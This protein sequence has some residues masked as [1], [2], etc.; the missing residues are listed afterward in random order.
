MSFSTKKSL[1]LCW[2]PLQRTAHLNRSTKEWTGSL[3]VQSNER[4]GKRSST[5][6]F[7]G[8]SSSKRWKQRYVNTGVPFRM[9]S[10]RLPGSPLRTDNAEIK[11][12]LTA[13]SD[14]AEA[15]HSRFTDIA[16]DITEAPAS[17]I[18]WNSSGHQL[19]ASYPT[20]RT[21]SGP[22]FGVRQLELVLRPFRESLYWAFSVGRW[23][24]KLTGPFTHFSSRAVRKN[25]LLDNYTEHIRTTP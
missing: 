16:A 10:S 5:D 22:F 23:H 17:G 13:K 1:L 25:G 20:G 21:L 15:W 6:N 3:A 24:I 4:H 8:R 11:V 2:S 12:L 19:P 18:H 7:D 9:L 14:G